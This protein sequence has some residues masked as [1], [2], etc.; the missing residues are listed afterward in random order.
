MEFRAGKFDFLAE[1]HVLTATLKA[2]NTVLAAD[3]M[4][5]SLLVTRAALKPISKEKYVEELVKYL[6]HVRAYVAEQHTK[7]RESE[8][9]ARLRSPFTDSA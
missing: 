8:Q 3:G 6:K 9:R 4:M 2:C 7:V 5:L 1:M